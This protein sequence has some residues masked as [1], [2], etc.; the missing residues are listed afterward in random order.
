ML[1]SAIL[2]TKTYVSS[3]AGGVASTYR[4][5]TVYISSNDFILKQ[6]I[7]STIPVAVLTRSRCWN[8]I[9]NWQ[10]P[11]FSLSFKTLLDVE[12]LSIIIIVTVLLE[13]WEKEG[14]VI[15]IRPCYTWAISYLPHPSSSSSIPMF[16]MD[17]AQTPP[18]LHCPTP[19]FPICL[20]MDKNSV[21]DT[22]VL[23]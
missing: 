14:G 7:H 2:V 19:Q 10:T 23:F 1:F 11:F 21:S 22:S 20:L 13:D 15:I 6:T 18:I 5:F 17:K 16:G 3:S 12:I 8:H 4:V 9:V